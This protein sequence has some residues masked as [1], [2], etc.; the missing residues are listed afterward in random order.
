MVS[1]IATLST[2]AVWSPEGPLLEILKLWLPAVVASK[3]VVT[4]GARCEVG[5]PD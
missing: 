3:P 5:D 4:L 1:V 2:K